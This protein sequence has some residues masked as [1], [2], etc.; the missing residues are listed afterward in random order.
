MGNADSAQIDQYM[1]CMRK[2]R[3]TMSMMSCERAPTCTHADVVNHR[4]R[5]MY[6]IKAAIDVGNRGEAFCMLQQLHEGPPKDTV[7]VPAEIP[8]EGTL[9]KALDSTAWAEELSELTGLTC[10]SIRGY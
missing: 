5:L 3:V 10:Y 9:R 1:E 7:P 6:R 4:N 2:D 8:S